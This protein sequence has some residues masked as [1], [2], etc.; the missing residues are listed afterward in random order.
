[1]RAIAP[2]G[3]VDISGEFHGGADGE[4]LFLRSGFGMGSFR[5]ILYSVAGLHFTLDVGWKGNGLMNTL[6]GK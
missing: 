5:G 2:K 3:Y 1:M 6:C 4:E